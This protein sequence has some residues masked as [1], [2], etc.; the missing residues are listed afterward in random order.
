MQFYEQVFPGQF[1]FADQLATYTYDFCV[2]LGFELILVDTYGDGLNGTATGGVADGGVTITACAMTPLF[3]SWKIYRFLKRG[4][5]WLTLVPVFLDPCPV[6][7]PVIGC[8]D[9]D[10]VDYNPEATEPGDCITLHT[11]GCMD[12]TAFNY[13]ADATI[14]DLNSPCVTTITLEDDAVTVGVT[15]T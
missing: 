2:S 12:T 9:D 6:E 14:S 1:N 11:W 13:D 3:G 4:R 7:P 8:M 10:Y 5:S 15:H